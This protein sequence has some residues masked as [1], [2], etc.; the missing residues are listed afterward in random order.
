MKHFRVS[1]LVTLACLVA[2]GWWGY[3]NSGLAG[4]LSAVGIAAILGVMEVSLSFDNA[5]VN[6]SVLKTW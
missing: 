6:A 4:A 1:F 5:V 3:S 2:A